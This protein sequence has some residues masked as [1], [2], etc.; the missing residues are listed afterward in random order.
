MQTDTLSS[1]SLNGKN[2][3]RSDSDWYK[4]AAFKAMLWDVRRVASELA[5]RV[6]PLALCVMVREQ[7]DG[8][9]IVVSISDGVIKQVYEVGI[10]RGLTRH[11]VAELLVDQVRSHRRQA[12]AAD[13]YLVMPWPWQLT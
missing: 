8:P 12:A 6:H 10:P 1:R 13:Y 3:A 9:E 7:P 11:N 2:R 4:R 5:S